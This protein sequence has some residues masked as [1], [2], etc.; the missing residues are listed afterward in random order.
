MSDLGKRIAN[1][2][3][4]KRALLERHL[5]NKG[6]SSLLT[7]LEIR[8]RGTSDPCVLS[9]AQQRLWFLDQLEPNSSAYN[10]SPAL[11]LIGKLDAATLEQS[12][13]EIIRRHEVLRTT[14]STENDQPLQRI[15]PAA[16]FSLSQADL[17]AM[18][19]R[20]REAKAKQLAT[21]EASRPFN[22][23]SG[24]LLRATLL[25]LNPEDHV[26][27]LTMHHII[28]DGWSMGVLYRELSVLY[29]AFLKGK[30]SPLPELPIQ[31]ADFAVWQREWLQGKKL[32]EQ[33]TFWKKQLNGISPLDL[34]TDHP[35][36]SVQTFHGAKHTVQ[37]PMDL[38]EALQ[39]LSRKEGA[40]L[41]MTL[42]TAF[43]SLLHRYTGQD[44]IV[45]GTPI[46]N[47]NRAEIEGLIGFFV[48]TLVMR[49]DISGNP[50]FR[51]LLK[52][53]RKSTLDAY[54]H[55]DL[56]FEK[57]IMELQPE[58]DL[59]RNPIFQLMFT[60]QNV[61]LSTLE[62]PAL[63]VDRLWIED[64]RTRFD[65]EVDLSE[66]TEGLKCTFVYNTDL[67]D[68][69]T[70]ER[71]A[72]HYQMILEGI[73]AN[74]DLRLSELPLLTEAERHKLLV[75]WNN[76]AADYP[77]DKCIHELFEEQAERSP[78]AFAVA[79]EE[80]QMTY[81]EL[82]SRANQLAHYLMKQGV[83]PEV[84]VGICVERSLE[85]I[86]GILGILKAG[87]AYVPLDPM[88]PKERLKFM[89]EDSQATVLMTQQKIAEGLPAIKSRVICLDLPEHMAQEAKMP[90]ANPASGVAAENLAYI[91]YTSGSTGW[92]KGVAV[93]HRQIVNYVRGICE[94]M[95]F[96]PAWHFAIVS[97]IAVDLGNTVVFPSVCTGG[98]LHVISKER[99]TDS[100]ALAEY[101]ERNS[102]DCL[103]IVPSHLAALMTGPHPEKLMPRKRLIL[104]G[105][106]SRCEWVEG[107]RKL[108]P[109]CIIFN[110]YG[111][112]ETTVGV[113][114]YQVDN[115]QPCLP[116]GMLP[117]RLPLSNTQIYILDRHQEPV[118]I[119]VP[120]EMYIGGDGVA[121]GY[122]NRSE[123]TRE[124][125]VSHP[126]SDEPG[127]RLYKTGDRGR[128][129]PNGDI[130]F[131]G[132]TDDQIKIRGFRIEPGEIETA[133][134]DCPG[135]R[136]AAVIAHE[137]A[138]GN[139]RL[140]AYIV[141]SEQ[142]TLASGQRSYRLPNGLIVAHLNKN[143][144]DYIYREIF[145]LQAYLR[146]G[147]TVNGGDVVF[148]VGANIGL[149][150]VFVNQICERPRVYAFE[151]N[152]VVH[153]LA[154]I[155]ARAYGAD[156]KMLPCGL[157][158]E[159]ATAEL[160][161]FEGFSLL[162]G[163]YSDV[164]KEKQVVKS[165]LI[166]QQQT[167]Q[168]DMTELIEQA[169]ELLAGR[170]KARQF[171]ATLRTLSGVIA[172]EKVDRIDLLKIN[173]EKSEWHVLQGIEEKDWSKIRQIVLEVDLR[174]HLP[175]ITALLKKHG[176]EYVV[177][178]D[179]LLDGTELCYI[180][181]IRPATGRRLLREQAAGGHLRK[182]PALSGDFLSAGELRQQLLRRLPEYMIP[183]AFVMMDSLPLTPN[184]KLDRKALPIPES[185]RTD[186]EE[187][188]VAT[189]TP[190]E[191]MLFFIWCEIL[192]L[193]EIGIHDNFFELGGH[194]LLATQV[195]SRLRKAFKLEIPLKSLF[196][197]PT[198]AGLAIRIAQNQAED[199]TPEELDRLLA[200]LEISASDT[201]SESEKIRVRRYE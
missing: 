20:Q 168:A 63:T 52:Q 26:L 198:I 71:M 31:Y 153:E 169:D 54:A 176:Y 167:A 128:F 112:T 87:G 143:E 126:F 175:P 86:I 161:F 91:I 115:E 34:F 82:N 5:L 191:E 10:M 28:S 156:V 44:D 152:P 142:L 201:V 1:L 65:L 157:S 19:E 45:V 21:E 15:I 50:V 145:E 53:V 185:K 155:N 40:T 164:E 184:G 6:I 29:E 186:M 114:T 8:R 38:T 177:E 146:H 9:F 4:E 158:R 139:A 188:Y 192:D 110:H 103:K 101:L 137:N 173:A 25:R 84:L 100:A 16:A 73:A 163:F 51:E 180:Y 88:Y 41:F 187:S 48:N 140:A 197:S 195:I 159:D 178:Q 174:E 69:A 23:T 77:R 49:T 95:E 79:F 127:A 111:P 85:M 39:G 179:A 35:R 166:N 107:L 96:G 125:F 108:A 162:S 116:S 171:T 138:S 136:D 104:G 147:I 190:I 58:R 150:T 66:T 7:K 81:G 130:E 12:L 106:A 117:L 109:D 99:A 43:Q 135:V 170:F 193:K 182:L 83:G 36:P 165:F 47:R 67:F 133:L 55:Q 89:L 102:I 134:C 131:L 119:R 105:E 14:F 13:C 80:R 189:R 181:A 11:Q 75:E 200:E 18:P 92:P 120:G 61:P 72:G 78:E 60:L 149:F 97:T 123:L 42:L 90:D 70:V 199:T 160:T 144:T 64:T 141:P 118:P 76:T 74:P 56:P 196:E 194:S 122:L 68:S 30:P 148:D 33:L 59:S 3:P 129:L 94:R 24:P 151:P 113:L 17:T 22:L 37:L 132:R 32:E 183:S 93:E 98:C 57:L 172:E 2:T 46:A 62:L 121:R 27:L 124:K 154:S